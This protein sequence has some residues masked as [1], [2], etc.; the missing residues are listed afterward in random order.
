MGNPLCFGHPSQQRVLGQ[1]KR[2]EADVTT[3]GNE[4]TRPAQQVHAQLGKQ[5]AMSRRPTD[6]FEHVQGAA[7]E[8]CRWHDRRQ[9]GQGG[10]QSCRLL[11]KT[12]N[13]K[14]A[15]LIRHVVVG[16]CSHVRRFS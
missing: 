8:I 5:E 15:A 1:D 7:Q 4:K 13:P 9:T 12:T 11:L 16:L 2:W 10:A 14:L 3:V 6:G